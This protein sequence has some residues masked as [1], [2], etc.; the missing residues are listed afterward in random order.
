MSK[1]ES[2]PRLID[3]WP[4]LQGA[5]DWNR[6]EREQ[7]DLNNLAKISGFQVKGGQGKTVT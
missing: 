7:E 6:N 2:D 5:T 1:K 3:R 4:H